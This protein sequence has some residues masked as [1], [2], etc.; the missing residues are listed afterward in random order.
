MRKQMEWR[1]F[2]SVKGTSPL[3]ATESFLRA[4][5]FHQND[6]HSA[7]VEF[8]EE[9]D[10]FF[11]WWTAQG[12]DFRPAEQPAGFGNNRESEWEEIAT[13]WGKNTKP[14]AAAC[15]FFDE[16]VHDSRASFKLS[17]P[18]NERLQIAE[19]N[20]W[21]RKLK[22]GKID[23]LLLDD[24]SAEERRAA[25]EFLKTN[26]IPRFLNFGRESCSAP[27]WA[28]YLR[29]RKIYSGADDALIA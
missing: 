1:R 17:G 16:L 23:P 19:L 12:H 8:A 22:A 13:W 21:A 26:Q 15:R 24:L 14:S 10:R 3:Q 5:V 29:Y 4:S 18:D 7:G 27:V 28:G 9:V 11:A 20:K 6:L 2:R 25:H